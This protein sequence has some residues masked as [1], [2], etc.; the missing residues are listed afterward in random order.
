MTSRK[1]C[2]VIKR[3][4]AYVYVYACGQWQYLQLSEFHLIMCT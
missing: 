3:N 2:E 4:Y 1:K